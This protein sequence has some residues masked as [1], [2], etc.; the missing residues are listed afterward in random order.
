MDLSCEIEFRQ[1]IV[2]PQTVVTGKSA[3]EA[4]AQLLG[5]CIALQPPKD[6]NDEVVV[7]LVIWRRHITPI[8]AKYVPGAEHL[9]KAQT[10]LVE[11]I[12]PPAAHFSIAARYTLKRNSTTSPS[13]MTYSL[14]SIRTF[15]A[16]FAAAI[17]PA[18]T[19]SS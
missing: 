5:A 11:V 2:R 10:P 8:Y 17:E 6:R 16:A 3:N 1:S 19:R 4:H 9:R 7:F 13:T 14:P 12:A 15:P 18:S